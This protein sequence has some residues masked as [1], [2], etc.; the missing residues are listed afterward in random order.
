M[1]SLARFARGTAS[2][3]HA[4]GLGAR[5]PTALALVLVAAVV[6]VIVLLGARV[7][8]ALGVATMAGIYLVAYAVGRPAAA[9]AAFPALLLVNGLLVLALGVDVVA[10]GVG[11]TGVL[12]LLWVW[13]IARGRARERGCF[14]IETAGMLAFGAI[15]VLAVLVDP[16]LGGVL[17]GV[18]WLTHGMWD[19]YHFVRNKIVN[20]PWSEMCAV[21][22]IPVGIALIVTSLAA[23]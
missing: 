11:M 8:F 4:T 17:A 20:R 22:D 2:R 1:T 12:V 14:T 3:W 18:G 5:W 21:V 23:A 6:P 19:G 15:T 9:W 16:A 7:E 13:V 10:L